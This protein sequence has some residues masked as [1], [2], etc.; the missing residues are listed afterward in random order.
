[1][2]GQALPLLGYAHGW[3]GIVTALAAR[4]RTTADWDE[5]AMITSCLERA[6][7]FPS[8]LLAEHDQWRDY[9]FGLSKEPLN[10]SWCNGIPGILIGLAACR[11][12]CGDRVSRFGEVLAAQTVQT[13]GAGDIQRFCCGEMGNVDW[14]LDHA[15]TLAPGAATELRQ[16]IAET[17]MRAVAATRLADGPLVPE[18]AFPGL[19]H[20]RAGILYTAL[21]SVV[22]T[23]PSLAGQDSLSV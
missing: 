22:P 23:L 15:G 14:C 12:W 20:G 7:R 8:R 5:A 1:M 18:L 6:A 19:F 21:R 16:R 11:S 4:Q 17:A 2:P 9:R 10:K 3:S 13:L